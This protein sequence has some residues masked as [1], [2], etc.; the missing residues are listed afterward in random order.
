MRTCHHMTLAQNSIAHV[1]QCTECE[2]VSIHL[3]ATTVRIDPVALEALWVVLR[4]AAATLHAKRLSEL[5]VR[6]LS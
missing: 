3:G 1:Q 2:C 6:E 4:E 5:D